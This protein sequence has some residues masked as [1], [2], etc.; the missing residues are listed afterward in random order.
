MERRGFL[1][2]LSAAFAA[3]GIVKATPV[4]S[5][6]VATA[7]TATGMSIMADHAKEVRL[8]RRHDIICSPKQ[9]EA[10]DALRGQYPQLKSVTYAAAPPLTRRDIDRIEKMYSRD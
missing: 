2:T 4:E 3:V 7:R 8:G 1:K 10:L 6:P 5:A 9:K